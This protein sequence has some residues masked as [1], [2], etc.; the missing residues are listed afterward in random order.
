[1][2]FE[3]HPWCS[4]PRLQLRDTVEKLFGFPCLFGV[5][6]QLLRP[7]VLVG[8]EWEVKAPFFDFCCSVVAPPSYVVLCRRA[9]LVIGVLLWKTPLVY[10]RI[11]NVFAMR[12]CG[13]EA[14]GR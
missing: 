6:A 13:W 14:V 5:V 11:T 4:L 2:R 10:L 1:M 8:R 9:L 3:P 7:G 12:R